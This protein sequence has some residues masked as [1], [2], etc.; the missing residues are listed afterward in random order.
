[1]DEISGG[2]SKLR[3]Q[4]THVDHS[5]LTEEQR[6]ENKNAVALADQL[7]LDI[8]TL[9]QQFLKGLLT[10]ERCMDCVRELC[11]DYARGIG[12]DVD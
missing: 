9:R 10:K 1:M 12:I 11:E 4:L 3:L 6:H 7:A 2:I 8:D 5:K